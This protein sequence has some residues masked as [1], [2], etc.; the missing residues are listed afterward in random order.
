LLLKIRNDSGETGKR[1]G[2][3]GT[4]TE[5]EKKSEINPAV[6]EQKN[7]SSTN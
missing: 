4:V 1:Y 2:V 5:K 7:F 6:P 3:N